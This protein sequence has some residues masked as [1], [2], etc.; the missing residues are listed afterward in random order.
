MGQWTAAEK[1]CGRLQ[2]PEGLPS[3]QVVVCRDRVPSFEEALHFARLALNT[4]YGQ[5]KTNRLVQQYFRKAVFIDL[6]FFARLLWRRLDGDHYFLLRTLHFFITARSV[7]GFAS[8]DDP[9]VQGYVDEQN[10]KDRG[11]EHHEK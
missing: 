10:S 6:F 3:R 1:R 4:L 5:Q 2:P 11:Q 7:L 9:S 8:A